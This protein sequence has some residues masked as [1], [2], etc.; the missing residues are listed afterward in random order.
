MN[1][2][3][4]IVE[5][6]RKEVAYTRSIITESDLQQTEA[7]KKPCYSLKKTLTATGSSGIIAEFKRKSPSKG[8]INKDQL[9][10]P[11]IRGY[12]VAGAAGVSI[13][14]DAEFF[15][16]GLED[17]IAVRTEE[18]FSIPV[19][20]KDF[21][22]DEFQVLQT[23]SL[24]ADVMLL[25][26]AILTIDEVYKLASKAKALG[27]EV[28][29]EIHSSNEIGHI[30]EYIDFVGV[31]NRNLKTF[32]VDIQKSLELAPLIPNDKI[33]ISESGINH[34]KDV[35]LLKEHGFKGFLVGD[36]FMREKDPMRACED[37]IKSLNH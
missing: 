4:T 24:G 32:E 11:T 27:L 10:I 15:G 37:F 16:G 5:H 36:R 18:Q 7:F 14:T 22:I 30:N 6:K 31:N 20:R 28:L 34:A 8:W 19:L 1:I 3:D 9:V 29:L 13:L 35:I 33:M 23:K 26:A 2:L 12:Q 17:V 25:I 21:I